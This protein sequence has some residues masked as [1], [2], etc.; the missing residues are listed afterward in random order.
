ML[1][2]HAAALG[3]QPHDS[4]R[5]GRRPLPYRKDGYIRRCTCPVLLNVHLHSRQ[6]AQ[7]WFSRCGIKTG[8]SAQMGIT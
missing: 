3:A 7:A 4:S 1:S 8:S 2:E 5:R 6:Q